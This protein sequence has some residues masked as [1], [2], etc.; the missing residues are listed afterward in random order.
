VFAY[1]SDGLFGVGSS[2][3]VTGIFDVDLALFI[4][5]SKDACEAERGQHEQDVIACL[6]AAR[7]NPFVF[8]GRHWQ[9]D[10]DEDPA[11]E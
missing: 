4:L 6:E 10:T 9:Q 8:D 1:Y 3:S 11:S 2:G 5:D 7:G